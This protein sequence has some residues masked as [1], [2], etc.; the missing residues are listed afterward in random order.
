ML[1]VTEQINKK[2]NNEEDEKFMQDALKQAVMAFESG[3]VPVGAVL[4]HNGKIIGKAHNQVEL[5]KDVTAHSEVIAISSAGEY[6][7]TKYFPD[8]TL[9]VTLEPCAMCAG[10]IGWA[11]IGRL[12]FAASDA[13]K[14]YRVKAP[15]VLHPK[16]EVISGILAEPAEKL[17]LDFFKE[18]R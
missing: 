11:Q 17:M 8:C 18:R 5:L 10:A 6:L 12:V 15:E 9:Y 14:G 2:N 1:T 7:Q 13:K 4:V 3:E 16:C